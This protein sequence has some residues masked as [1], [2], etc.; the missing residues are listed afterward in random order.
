MSPFAFGCTFKDEYGATVTPSDD[1]D[2]GTTFDDDVG[3]TLIPLDGEDGGRT[4]Q[5][6]IFRSLILSL[7]SDMHIGPISMKTDTESTVQSVETE[8]ITY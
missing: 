2:D 7:S 3:R 1:E 8:G 6:Y 4:G 5:K